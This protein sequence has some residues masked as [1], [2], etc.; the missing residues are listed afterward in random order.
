M[1]TIK[2]LMTLV[3]SIAMV[4]AMGVTALAAENSV[5]T[6]SITIENAATGHTYEAYQIFTGELTKK[7]N[8][9]ILSNVVWGNGVSPEKTSELGD[10]K[11]KAESL[12]GESQ[13]VNLAKAVAESLQNPTESTVLEGKYVINVS[14]PG[15]YLVKD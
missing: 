4:L 9:L 7:D 15:Y 12:T 5:S 11:A 14:E 10:A 8:K 13:A 1:K 3:L 6:Y 2:K